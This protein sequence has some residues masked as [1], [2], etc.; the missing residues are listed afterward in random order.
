ML[1]EEGSSYLPASGNERD[2]RRYVMAKWMNLFGIVL[3]LCAYGF[4]LWY[5]PVWWLFPT[6]VRDSWNSHEWLGVVFFT[7]MTVAY[8][9]LFV[10]TP[11]LWW[12]RY[13]YELSKDRAL[14]LRQKVWR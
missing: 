7:C 3:G 11:W 9:S 14:R 8:L 12:N 2:Y 13:K 5:S 10:A 1:I 4:F 6:G